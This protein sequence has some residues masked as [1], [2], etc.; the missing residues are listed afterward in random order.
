[1][2]TFDHRF[3]SKG[4]DYTTPDK[5]FLPLQEEFNFQM[6]VA[7]SP[8][9]TKCDRYFTEEDNALEQE[10]SEMNWCNPP[11]GSGLPKWVRKAHAEKLKGRTTVMLLPIRSNT[12]YWR[13]HILHGNVITRS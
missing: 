13:E 6:D 5:L 3:K 4:I 11:Y 1:M 10:W 12:K 9:N 8:H 7:A 2:S